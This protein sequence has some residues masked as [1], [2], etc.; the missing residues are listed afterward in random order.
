MQECL[1]RVARHWRRVRVMEHPNAY[2]RKVLV[3][4][5]LDEGRHRTRYRAELAS[6][7]SSPVE[8]REDEAAVRAFVR[9]ETNADLTSALGE[10]AP[11]QRVTLVFRYFDDMSEAQVAEVMGCSV[12]T[13]K[14]TTSRALERLR[15]IVERPMTPQATVDDSTENAS[16]E[17]TDTE[18]KEG[19]ITR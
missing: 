12:G 4:L 14:S 17:N 6:S 16:T 9:V 10:L 7:G 2:A 11:R 19:S 15:D 5:A 8:E 3:N 18:T 1:F 13:V